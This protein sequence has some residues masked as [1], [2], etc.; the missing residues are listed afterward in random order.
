MLSAFDSD[1]AALVRWQW[2]CAPVEEPLPS[3]RLEE[4]PRCFLHMKSQPKEE[5]APLMC[6]SDQSLLGAGIR[7]Q[8]Y[9]RGLV[10]GKESAASGCCILILLQLLIQQQIEFCAW[11]LGQ[12]NGIA[13]TLQPE[14]DTCGDFSMEPAS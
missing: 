11:I 1:G 14:I 9:S 4:V 2:R 12:Q 10:K 5:I 13:K 8:S 3:P 7:R 6:G